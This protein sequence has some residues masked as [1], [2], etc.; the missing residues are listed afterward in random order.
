MKAESLTVDVKVGQELRSWVLAT[1]GTDIL[2]PERQSNL[3]CLV[4]QHLKTV[5]A[6][7]RLV[8]DRGEY[9]YIRLLQ[10]GSDTKAWNLDAG[11][12]IEVNTLY[13]SY[14]DE[15]GQYVVRRF[16]YRNFKSAFRNYMLGAVHANPTGKEIAAI[17]EFC[18]EYNIEVTKQLITRLQKDWIRYKKKLEEEVYNP[19]AF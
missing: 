11:R 4:K 12:T 10:S 16:L 8:Y 19:M 7:Y 13:R 9:I 2:V 6:S 17:T 5:P 1:A 3:W 14:L 18:L 15:R